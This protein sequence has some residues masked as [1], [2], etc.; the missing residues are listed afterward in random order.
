MLYP[1]NISTLHSDNQTWT[2]GHVSRAATCHEAVMFRLRWPPAPGLPPC[3]APAAWP[4]WAARS[5]G[6]QVREDPRRKKYFDALKNIYM[7]CVRC[8]AVVSPTIN[9]PC[10]EVL[11]LASR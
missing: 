6:L 11:L 1:A 3:P 4:S 2:R 8:V 5:S 10:G 7:L 9:I